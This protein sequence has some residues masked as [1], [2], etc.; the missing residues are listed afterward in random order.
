MTTDFYEIMTNKN[1][2]RKIRDY[3]HFHPFYETNF[4]QLIHKAC[5]NS[6]TVSKS[7]LFKGKDTKHMDRYSVL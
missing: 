7:E 3:I 2:L 5:T 6:D 1:M 4:G